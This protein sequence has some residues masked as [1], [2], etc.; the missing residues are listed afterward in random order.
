MLRY[1]Q[2]CD[3]H[4]DNIALKVFYLMHCVV[5]SKSLP[6]PFQNVFCSSTSGSVN[7]HSSHSQVSIV[8]DH[9][10]G[11]TTRFSSVCRVE[12]F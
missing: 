10:F 5:M 2:D 8:P 9:P 6:I 12:K 4:L 11:I 3:A 1:T 7:I